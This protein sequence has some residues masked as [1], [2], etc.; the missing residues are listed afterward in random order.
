VVVLA[1]AAALAGTDE[2]SAVS[3]QV[4][5]VTRTGVKCTS[6]GDC[7][8]LVAGGVDIDYDGLSGSMEFGPD[9][10]GIDAVFGVVT[11]GATDTVDPSRAEAWYVAR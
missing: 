1:L 9:G 8:A 11:Y 6:F 3:A 5:E 4:V 10:V 2:P 7:A